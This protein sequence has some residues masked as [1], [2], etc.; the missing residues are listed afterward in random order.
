MKGMHHSRE[1]MGDIDKFLKKIQGSHAK[2]KWRPITAL[3]DDNDAI[4]A[5]IPYEKL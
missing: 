4:A 2:N 3:V 1:A 5:V